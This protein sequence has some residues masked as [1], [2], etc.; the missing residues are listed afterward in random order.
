MRRAKPVG[1]SLFSFQNIPYYKA[2][3]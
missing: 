1:L 2:C 3:L